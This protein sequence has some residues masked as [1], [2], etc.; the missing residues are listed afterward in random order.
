MTFT[1]LK[2]KIGQRTKTITILLGKIIEKLK[3]YFEFSAR[4][5]VVY[6]N[7]ETQHNAKR[8]SKYG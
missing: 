5:L 7:P 8:N 4:A 2:E 1:K 3:G 6:F